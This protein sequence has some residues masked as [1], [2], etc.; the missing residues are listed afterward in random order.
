M[1]WLRS[2]VGVPL[3]L[4]FGVFE[5]LLTGSVLVLQKAACVDF[6]L[7]RRGAPFHAT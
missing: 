4:P 1:V 2:G 7:V 6:A 5:V 3:D